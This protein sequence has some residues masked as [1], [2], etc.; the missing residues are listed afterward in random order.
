MSSVR[1]SSASAKG[2]DKQAG[3]LK[4]ASLSA[5]QH[6]PAFGFRLSARWSAVRGSPALERASAGKPSRKALQGES[7]AEG[8]LT[9]RPQGGVLK[10]ETPSG[11]EDGRTPAARPCALGSERGPQR[12][13]DAVRVS[14]GGTK[15][16]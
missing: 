1:S 6:A 3:S 11:G 5:F 4:V 14:S 8:K 16:G 13:P 2:L 10:S 15:G 9:S 12:I 7:R